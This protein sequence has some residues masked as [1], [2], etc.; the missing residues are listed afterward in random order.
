ML[1]QLKTESIE[2]LKTLISIPSFSKKENKTADC[3]HDFFKKN[4]FL[5][6]EKEIMCG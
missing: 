2:L 6:S 3:I 5:L 1:Q 4:Q